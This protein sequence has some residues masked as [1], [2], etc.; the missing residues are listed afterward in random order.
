MLFALVI[1]LVKKTPETN[2]L[3]VD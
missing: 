3:Q 2:H 1:F